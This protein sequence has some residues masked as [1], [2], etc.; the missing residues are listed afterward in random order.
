MQFVYSPDSVRCVVPGSNRA[1][2][3]AQSEGAARGLDEIERIPDRDRL[4]RYPF[5]SAALGELELQRG[6]P[7]AARGHFDAARELARNPMERRFLEQ[8]LR[9]CEEDL[10][11]H[12]TMP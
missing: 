4:R 6:R 9:V 1:I 11:Q 7:E 10:W 8:R 12:G 5:Y 3:V 2:A